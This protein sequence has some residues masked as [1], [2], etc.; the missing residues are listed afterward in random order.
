MHNSVLR[1]SNFSIVV[2]RS[3]SL[4]VV[5]GCA[6]VG[7]MRAAPIHSPSSLCAIELRVCGGRP[8]REEKFKTG[9]QETAR[10]NTTALQNQFRLRP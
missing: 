8:I 6:G 1:H 2:L 5:Y 4:E 10:H 7:T 3:D 9:S